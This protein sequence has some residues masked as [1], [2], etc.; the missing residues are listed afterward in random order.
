MLLVENGVFLRS[1]GNGRMFNFVGFL[2]K[3]GCFVK[4]MMFL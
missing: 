3:K 2:G 1:S 4:K